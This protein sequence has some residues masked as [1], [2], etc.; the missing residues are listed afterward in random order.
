MPVSASAVWTRHAKPVGQAILPAAA[1]PGGLELT[2]R[3][4]RRPEEFRRARAQSRL[5]GGCSLDRLPHKTAQ[6]QGLAL[7]PAGRN[8]NRV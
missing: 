6:V 8:S 2:I 4:H 3:H 1:F 5:K 7:R